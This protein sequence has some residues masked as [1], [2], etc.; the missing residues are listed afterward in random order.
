MA[1]TSQATMR[2]LGDEHL[3]A[4]ARK[5]IDPCE[6]GDVDGVVS[7][8]AEDARAVLPLSTE[9]FRGSPRER[10]L[11]APARSAATSPHERAKAA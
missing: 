8:V 1:T 4:I 3:R 9:W 2:S 7:L 11:M 10:W 6:R 5:D